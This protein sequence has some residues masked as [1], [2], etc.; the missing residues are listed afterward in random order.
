MIRHFY[1]EEQELG[2]AEDC[3]RFIHG[4]AQH[5]YSY[6]WFCPACGEVWA[7]A[8]VSGAEKWIVQGGYCRK[9]PGPSP[10]T[11]AGSLMLSWEPEH[12]AMI[13][14]LPDALEWEFERHLEFFE[15]GS[16]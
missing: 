10:F 1:V 7:R 9:H 15:R 3:M 14:Q 5:P 16:Q 6:A 2:G 11:V 12:N 4:Q 13:Q 8:P